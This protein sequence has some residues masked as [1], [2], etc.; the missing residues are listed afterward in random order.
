MDGSLMYAVDYKHTTM[1]TLHNSFNVQSVDYFVVLGSV[2]GDCSAG[3]WRC[4][5]PRT[6]CLQAAS[7]RPV[8]L[9]NA[10]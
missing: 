6:L 2:R 3:L 8:V 5:A 10:T 1:L 4:H 7:S 9:T